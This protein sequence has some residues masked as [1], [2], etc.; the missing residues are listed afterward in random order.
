L[1]VI[2]LLSNNILK[3]FNEM[4]V[5]ERGFS[6]SNTDAMMLIMVNCINSLWVMIIFIFFGY[7]LK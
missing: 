4:N 6:R 1:T 2:S 3:P 7:C 5:Y